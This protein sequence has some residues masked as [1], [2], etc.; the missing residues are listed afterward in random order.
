[1]PRKARKEKGAEKITK[2][3]DSK[4][5]AFLATFLSI[6]G[7]ILVLLLD[8]KKDKYVMFYAKQSLVIFIVG[9]VLGAISWIL[10]II[11]VLGLIINWI[12]GIIMLIL[13]LFSWI[14]ALSEKMKET[15]IVGKWAEK[16]NL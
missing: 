16:I 5:Y 8:K 14:N 6:I 9:I 2:K 1:M 7:F 3:E 10:F 12:I 4:T 13:W 15:P 11:P